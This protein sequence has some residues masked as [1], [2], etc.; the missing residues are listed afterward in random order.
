[1]KKAPEGAFSVSTEA[2]VERIDRGAGIRGTVLLS[3]S[4]ER[5]QLVDWTCP[6]K[7]ESTN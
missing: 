4:L 2:G 5:Q 7:V 3:S 1:M 6:G